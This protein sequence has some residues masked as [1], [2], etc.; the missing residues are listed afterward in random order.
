MSFLRPFTALLTTGACL[1]TAV[2]LASPAA[3]VVVDS[4]TETEPIDFLETNFCDV[5]GAER[6]D[7]RG[8]AD[9]VARRTS[10]A[11]RHR[12]LRLQRRK[13]DALHQRGDRRLCERGVAHRRAGP[14]DHRREGHA[15]HRSAG[16]G[17]GEGARRVG[18]APRRGP[19]PAP[20]PAQ[21][22]ARRHANRSAPTTGRQC[23]SGSRASRPVAAT[24]SVRRSSRRSRPEQPTPGRPLA[25]VLVEDV[26]T[27]ICD[28]RAGVGS[29]GQAPGGV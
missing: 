7:H 9:S 21:G 29:A 22:A 23:L 27:K 5:R 25:A 11:G 12:L 8:L 3:S 1:L 16:H 18:Q 28:R 15:S 4:G 20:L 2:T 6:A 14:V 13:D 19:G 26:S 24:P 17:D 10:R